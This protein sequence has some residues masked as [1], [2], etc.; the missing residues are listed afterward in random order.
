MA[1]RNSTETIKHEFTSAVVEDG[2]LIYHYIDKG[3]VLWKGRN[4]GCDKNLG[5]FRIINLSRNKIG[6]EIPR[7]ISSLSQLN[8]LNLSNNKLAGAI[9]EEIGCLKQ[10][11]SLDLSQNQLSGRLPASLAELNFLNTLNL[12]NNNLSGRI[13]SSTQLQSFNESAFSDNLALCGS[14]LPQKCPGDNI[15]VSQ[16]NHSGQYN[17]KDGE[18][19]WKLFYVGMGIGFIVGFWGVSGTLLLKFKL[20]DKMQDWVYVRTTVYMRS[21]RHKFHS[22]SFF[23]K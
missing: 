5:R 3:L 16:K 12:S 2:F 21:S 8:Q 14:P 13:P 22:Y 1:D 15:Q 10:L 11:E 9:P 6:G 23:R 4:Y 7:E 20:L 19:F 18:E 17:K